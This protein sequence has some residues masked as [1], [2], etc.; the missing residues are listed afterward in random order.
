MSKQELII[1]SLRM[2]RDNN[3]DTIERLKEEIFE[4]RNDKSVNKSDETLDFYRK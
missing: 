1:E 3:L 2:S 4:L